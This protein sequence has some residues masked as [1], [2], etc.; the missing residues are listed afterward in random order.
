MEIETESVGHRKEEMFLSPDLAGVSGSGV[1]VSFA[2]DTNARSPD[3]PPD[4]TG[5]ESHSQRVFTTVGTK[6]L[7]FQNHLNHVLPTEFES[8]F[9]P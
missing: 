9:S 2:P 3:N 7:P 1:L 5:R 6:R 4:Q 8:V